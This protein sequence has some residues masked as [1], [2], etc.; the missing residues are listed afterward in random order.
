[1]PSARRGRAVEW[2]RDPLSWVELIALTNI[3]FLAVDV[4]LAHAVNAF[5]SPAEYVPVAFS[6]AASAVLAFAAVLGG[7]RPGLAGK[8]PRARRVARGLGLV[9]GWGSVAVGVAGV[10]LHLES[11]FFDEQTLHNLVY[12]APFAAP[13]AYTG[14]GLLLILNRTTDSASDEWARWVV[15]LALG[16]FVG[17]LVLTLADH[18][19]N[20]FFRPSEWIG[21]A[22][23]AWAVSSLTAVLAD[24]GSRLTLRLALGVMAAQVVVALL[25]F[26]L[27]V[28]ADLHAPQ[29]SLWDRLLYGAPVFAPLLFADL[30]LLAVL[31]IWAVA[32]ARPA[33][34]QGPDLPEDPEPR[35]EPNL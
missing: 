21:V 6:V 18:A 24:A 26:G 31:G 33:A 4:S 14:V 7:L 8:G 17:N 2:W 23:A 1:V 30:A 32:T 11:A 12:T 10:V 29:T 9:V 15:L 16:G 22:A 13:L 27:H 19:Q 34:P 35:N 28:A 3:A 25:G 20:G 5:A